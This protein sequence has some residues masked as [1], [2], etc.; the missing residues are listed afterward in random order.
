[1]IESQVLDS[2]SVSLL[3]WVFVSVGCWGSTLRQGKSKPGLK[4]ERGWLCGA[5]GGVSA[6]TLAVIECELDHDRVCLFAY[7]VRG[8]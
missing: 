2:L 8:K 4:T 7:S 3:V 5:W 1:M 6:L